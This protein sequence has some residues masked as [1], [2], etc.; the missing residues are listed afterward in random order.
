MIIHV[1]SSSTNPYFN[2]AAE[3][4]LLK[5]YDDDVFMLWRSAPS[6]IVGKHQNALAEINY[7]YLRENK[8]NLARRLTGGGTVVH[9][10]Q[11]LNFT[12]IANG[13]KGKLI[14][15]KKFVNP[16]VDYLKTLG[17]NSH[18]GEKNDIRIGELKISGNAEHVYKTR[19]L[20]H[21]TLLFN[22][23]LN[24]LKLAIKVNPNT[25]IDKAVQSN[26]STV[27]NICEHLK[28][29]LTIEEFTNGLSDFVLSASPKHV[30][31][32][33][34][35]DE[36]SSINQLISDKYQTDKWIYGY[37]PKYQFTKNF[38][39]NTENWSIE[40]YVEKSIVVKAQLAINDV[41]HPMSQ[42]LVGV[43]H[44]FDAIRS[45]LQTTFPALHE[46]ELEDLCYCFF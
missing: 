46:A 26:R 3:E 4:Y 5:N 23:D 16:V 34:T 12:F 17:I 29:K 10:L 27:S 42:N 13:N 21:G 1:L 6:V 40:I 19:V 24:K 7:Q 28:Q 37:S 30:N 14:D 8:V 9:D 33:L 2:I 41:P 31:H 25:Y 38:T 11:N 36:I 39:F 43:Y 20:H 15:F 22:S 18:I 35:D 44:H 32:Q 45:L